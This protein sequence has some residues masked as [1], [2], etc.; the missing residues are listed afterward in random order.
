MKENLPHGSAVIQKDARYQYSSCCDSLGVRIPIQI[1][2][3]EKR[4][5]GHVGVCG[6]CYRPYREPTI[7]RS[8]P[9]EYMSVWTSHFKNK[10]GMERWA[11]DVE[12]KAGK[13][14]PFDAETTTVKNPSI[15]KPQPMGDPKYNPDKWIEG[16]EVPF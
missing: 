8:A 11:Y 6:K 13:L 9:R 10:P 14:V 5:I 7:Y 16:D 1:H 12:V 2:G 4:E 15:P 3:T